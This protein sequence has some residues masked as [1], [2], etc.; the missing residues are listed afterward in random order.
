MIFFSCLFKGCPFQTLTSREGYLNSPNY[1]HF[2]LDNLDCTFIVQ[3][4]LGKRVW[5]ELT[6]YE[7]T[8][9]CR[10]DIDVGDGVF[11]PF[12]ERRH[13]NDGVFVSRSERLKIRLK[14]GG[15]PR[16]R[17]FRAIYKTS[18]FLFLFLFFF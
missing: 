5:L 8:D 10:L 3:A 7:I 18:K 6:D 9:D 4:P 16:G 14:S 17:G 2:L 12:I 13:L 11:V 1:P 15:K